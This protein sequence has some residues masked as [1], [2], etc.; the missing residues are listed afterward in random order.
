MAWCTDPS[1]R[2][3]WTG[4]EV[5][6]PEG[7]FVRADVSADDG[8]PDD[9]AAAP[10]R[11]A[12]AAHRHGIA[13]AERRLLPAGSRRGAWRALLGGRHPRESV[14]RDS[15][16]GRC[17]AT[18]WRSRSAP[19]AASSSW[20]GASPDDVDRDGKSDPC[21]DDDD[22]DGVLDVDDN[23]PKIPNGGQEAAAAP[24]GAGLPAA[25]ADVGLQ[26]DQEQQPVHA[27]PGLP[28]RGRRC[29]GSRARRAGGGRSV[30]A[31]HG[32]G[33]SRQLPRLLHDGCA[34]GR[35]TAPCGCAPTSHGS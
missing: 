30:A 12:R 15:S 14:W 7:G 32:P 2:E 35:S 9:R 11:T 23:C 5:E 34:S 25:L 33:G 17:A 16:G 22:G 26:V 6:V 20:P 29:G 13:Y 24:H 10:A 18:G 21:D 27:Q 1:V 28:R 3:T 4:F 19:I 31:V 8:C